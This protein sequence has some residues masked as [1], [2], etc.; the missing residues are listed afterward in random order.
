MICIAAKW[1]I[2]LGS[3]VLFDLFITK[4]KS[5]HFISHYLLSISI[6][7]LIFSGN[8]ALKTNRM[9]AYNSYHLMLLKI[10][11]SVPS[12]IYSLK[13]M[14]LSTAEKNTLNYNFRLDNNGPNSESKT[15]N[16][17]LGIMK[18]YAT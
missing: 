14:C 10:Y 17:P 7:E 6:H 3:P 16:L 11:M 8:Q 4:V 1:L 18:L 9:E 13:L 2:R 5:K 12:G 15:S